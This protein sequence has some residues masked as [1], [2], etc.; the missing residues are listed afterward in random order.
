MVNKQYV[1]RK[2]IKVFALIATGVFAFGVTSFSIIASI[3]NN[4]G[5]FT[6]SLKNNGPIVS[7]DTSS[8]FADPKT[9]YR[10]DQL[11]EFTTIRSTNIPS[12]DLID[13]ENYASTIGNRYDVNNVIDGMYFYKFTFYIKNTGSVVANYNINLQLIENVKPSNTVYGLDDILRV[14][15]F[16]NSSEDHTYVDYAKQSITTKTLPDGT[17]SKGEYLSDEDQTLC[18]SFESSDYVFDRQFENLKVGEVVRYTLL[19]YLE[20]S[21][22]ECTGDKPHDGSLKLGLTFRTYTKIDATK[23]S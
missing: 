18:T 23:N 14:R 15:F 2:K 11:P 19:F 3:G 6:I 13:N 20:G 4:L 5:D 16:E 10:V 8:G 22:P 21:D 17:T 7:L 1:K 12:I 9:F